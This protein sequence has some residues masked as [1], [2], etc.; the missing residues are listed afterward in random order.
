LRE[1][2]V[3]YHLF[4]ALRIQAQSLRMGGKGAAFS[5]RPPAVLLAVWAFREVNSAH[6]VQNLVT[7]TTLTPDASVVAEM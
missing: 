3:T 2:F 1:L 4:G 7:R 6:L 5:R